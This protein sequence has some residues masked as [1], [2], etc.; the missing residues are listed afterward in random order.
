[1]KSTGKRPASA[2]KKQAKRSRSTR[3]EIDPTLVPC[4][5]PSTGSLPLESDES[6][7]V[8]V[9]CV[10]G[11]DEA[12]RGPV[13]GP[14]VYGAAYCALENKTQLNAMGF[15]DSKVLKVAERD[16]L[17]ARIQQ[18]VEKPVRYVHTHTHTHTHTHAYIHTHTYIS[19]YARIC[20]LAR[21]HTRTHNT[22]THN[23]H[24]HIHTLSCDLLVI[25]LRR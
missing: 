22:H 13:M 16:M 18:S 6:L 20:T 12:G 2:S 8:G 5:S 10:L 25:I 21:A 15:D 14:M 19:T 7:L 4:V 17:F 3:L 9:P 11:I 23:T 24:T 1:V